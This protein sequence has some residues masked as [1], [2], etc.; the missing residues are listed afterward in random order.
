MSEKTTLTEQ[1][2]RAIEMLVDGKEYK[3]V[4][5]FLGISVETIRKLRNDDGEFARV[6]NERYETVGDECRARFISLSPIMQDMLIKLALDEKTHPPTK[7]DLGK[8]FLNMAGHVPIKRVDVT[9]DSDDVEK[10]VAAC[11]AEDDDE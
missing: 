2:L 8:Y 4:A 3:E 1:Q 6:L 5:K 9:G 10:M 7:A 11:L